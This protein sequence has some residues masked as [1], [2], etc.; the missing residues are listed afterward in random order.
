MKMKKIIIG[1][2]ALC[3]AML[4]LTSCSFLLGKNISMESEEA[5]QT[6]KEA[7]KNNA[8][9][10]TGRVS[11]ISWS[12]A[13][14]SKKLDNYLGHF[15]IHWVAEDNSNYTQDF[16]KN[17]KGEFI[18]SEPK[19]GRDGI[20]YEYVKPFDADKLDAVKILKQINDGK[21]LL[22]DEYEFASVEHYSI[23]QSTLDMRLKEVFKVKVI[24]E[25][26][27]I[28]STGFSLNV[29]KKGKD[30]K[31]EGKHI[32]TNY[33]TVSFVVGEDGSVQIREK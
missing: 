26:Y 16:T 2:I 18:G 24:P 21:L 20:F 6:I 22:D 14:G 8:N 19:K 11:G 30:S 31:L 7:I 29:Y 3:C 12:E 23:S 9:I 13:G 33:Y 4:N 15:Y 5:I 28:E 27:G 17:D 1:F 10:G 32:T 25:K